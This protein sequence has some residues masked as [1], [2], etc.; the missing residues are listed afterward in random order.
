MSLG[1]Q[2]HVCIERKSACTW[3]G[4][5]S[6]CV[7]A[8]VCVCVCVCVCMFVGGRGSNHV[9]SGS[10][11]LHVHGDQGSQCT[12]F[13]FIFFRSMRGS[14]PTSLKLKAHPTLKENGDISMLS[15][16]L[17]SSRR[18]DDF[19]IKTLQQKKQQ[20]V[21]KRWVQTWELSGEC[22]GR[23]GGEGVSHH[24]GL[25]CQPVSHHNDWDLVMCCCSNTGGSTGAKMKISTVT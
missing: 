23:I 1:H 18:V 19:D 4:Q 20:A 16:A 11:A 7:N 9:L 12:S 3:R 17:L 2:H 15:T 10:P 8:C 14:R 21:M 25:S 6:V 22:S 24:S 5:L 13:N